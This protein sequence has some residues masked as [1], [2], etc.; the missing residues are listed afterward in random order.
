M[1]SGICIAF[2]IKC[3]YLSPILKHNVVTCKTIVKLIGKVCWNC[4]CL[5]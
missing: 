3:P 4:L 5:L 2:E 1:I